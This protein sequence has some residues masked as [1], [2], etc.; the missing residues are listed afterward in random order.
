MSERSIGSKALAVA[1]QAAHGQ[2]AKAVD[3]NRGDWRRQA[4]QELSQS[5]QRYTDAI[6][7]LAAARE[8][9]SDEAT[10]VAWLD[11]GQNIEA[12]SDPL[13]GRL[14]SDAAGRQPVS[15]SRTLEDHTPRRP[16]R[17]QLTAPKRLRHELA[18]GG[19]AVSPSVWPLRAC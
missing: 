9:L 3:A 6:D 15:F 7:E 19:C 5:R 11:G 10:L 13:S 17:R 2:I 12:A 4:M 18:N 16:H 8:G 1:V 14:G